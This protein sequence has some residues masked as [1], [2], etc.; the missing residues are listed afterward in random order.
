MKDTKIDEHPVGNQDKP[1]VPICAEEQSQPQGP[2]RRELI[3][4]YGKYAL[5]A[6]PLLLFVSKAHAI[7]SRP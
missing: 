3:K 1:P 7:H 5:A 6:G 4:R 2:N